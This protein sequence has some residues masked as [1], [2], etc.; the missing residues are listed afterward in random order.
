MIEPFSITIDHGI[1]K[2][3][4]VLCT[5]P[6]SEEKDFSSFEFASKTM[7]NSGQERNAVIKFAQERP[8]SF[9]YHVTLVVLI[10]SY[11]H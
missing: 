5:R 9:G 1:E 6:L 7:E 8:D 3:Y 11:S 2:C 4:C 10:A